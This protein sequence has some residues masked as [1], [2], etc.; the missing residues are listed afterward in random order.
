MLNTMVFI[1]CLGHTKFFHIFSLPFAALVT[2]DRRGAILSPMNF[3]NENAETFGLG[4]L[5]ELNNEKYT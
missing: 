4:K 1:A 5:S 2:P 3:E